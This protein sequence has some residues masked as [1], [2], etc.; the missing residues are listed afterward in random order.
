[1]DSVAVVIAA[2]RNVVVFKIRVADSENCS[3]IRSGQTGYAIQNIPL[4]GIRTCSAR[5]PDNKIGTSVA[6]VISRINEVIGIKITPIDLPYLRSA[7]GI[8]DNPARRAVDVGN[9][10]DNKFISAVA[11][12]IRSLKNK[13]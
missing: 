2:H 10:T 13:D 6:R 11:G 9:I 4:T 5:A 8:A 7:D 12:K 1:M 3:V